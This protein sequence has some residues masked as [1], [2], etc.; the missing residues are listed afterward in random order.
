MVGAGCAI[1]AGGF[2]I[3]QVHPRL[4]A[5]FELFSVDLAVNDLTLRNMDAMIAT[6]NRR[7]RISY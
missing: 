7:H 6:P 5:E 4:L 2:L 1:A 3:Q